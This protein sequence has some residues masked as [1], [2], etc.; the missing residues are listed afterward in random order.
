ALRPPPPSPTRRSSDLSRMAHILD[1]MNGIAND[2][3]GN[4]RPIVNFAGEFQD[5]VN[6]YYNDTYWNGGP[7]F[8]ST[9]WYGQ[10]HAKRQDYSR[11]EEHT[12]ELQS[13]AYLV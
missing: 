10:Y 9:M 4:N 5:L 3:F 13:L 1:R 12:S 11:S 2:G 6:R 7:W 8:L